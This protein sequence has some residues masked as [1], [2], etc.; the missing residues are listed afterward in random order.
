MDKKDAEIIILKDLIVRALNCIAFLDGCLLHPN[1]FSYHYPEQTTNTVEMLKEVVVD[2][3]SGCYHSYTDKECGSCQ[4]WAHYLEVLNEA[5][6]I[7]NES[8]D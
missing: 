4:A 7:M 5:K 3:P 1:I 2:R 8:T 6:R